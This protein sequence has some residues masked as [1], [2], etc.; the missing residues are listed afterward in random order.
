MH[1]QQKQ[2]YQNYGIPYYILSLEISGQP[3]QIV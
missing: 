3:H 2:F 1:R